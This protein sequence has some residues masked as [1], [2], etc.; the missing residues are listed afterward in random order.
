MLDVAETSNWNLNKYAINARLS[1]LSTNSMNTL[2]NDLLPMVSPLQQ[3]PADWIPT[4]GTIISKMGHVTLKATGGQSKM[5]VFSALNIGSK[6]IAIV[7]LYNVNW[8]SAEAAGL[9]FQSYSQRLALMCFNKSIQKDYFLFESFTATVTG[10]IQLV[11]T[12]NNLA[13]TGIVPIGTSLVE[14]DSNLICIVPWTQAL[15]DMLSL[16]KSNYTYGRVLPISAMK[17]LDNKPV[18]IPVVQSLLLKSSYKK[19]V[20]MMIMYGQSLAVGGGAT[21]DMTNKK[22][23]L[24]FAGGYNEYASNL[25]IS[26][27]AQVSAYY[28]TDLVLLQSLSGLS[29]SPAGAAAVAWMQL[30]EAENVIDLTSFDY[31]FLLSTPGYS[32][33]SITGLIKGQVYYNRLLL[34]VQKGFELSLKAGKTFGVPV[35]FYVQ[36]EADM[37][38]STASFYA[39]LKQLFIDLNT[40][41]KAITGQT[42]DVKFIPYQ[43]SPVTTQSGYENSGPSFAQLQLALEGGNVYSAASMYQYTYGVGDMWHPA[44]RAVVG[45]QLGIIAK[46]I[47][48][49]ENPY[50]V[51][52]PKSRFV[53]NSGS[54]WVLNIEFNVP[55]APMRFDVSGDLWHNPNGKQVNYGFKLL[56]SSLANIISAEPTIKRGNTLVI[57]CTENPTGAKLSYAIDGHYG[58]GNLCDSQKIT[59]VN[60]STNYVVDN[61]CVAF[62]D[63][64]I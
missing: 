40:D 25:D 2:Q 41:I 51:F 14:F 57:K 62:K 63:Y 49:D 7:N 36:G 54:Y 1:D 16:V 52:Y 53:Q 61:F 31:Q 39:V 55:V 20:N 44:D 10:A 23:T 38:W 19:D 8:L 34:S 13:N 21:D 12:G 37:T 9:D 18:A 33:I 50:P 48:N 28:G 11:A 4:T 15:E 6:Y 47:V 29:H 59:I 17:A 5:N 24:S 58:G 64:V 56:N 26:V 60:K 43:T 45:Q 27:P 46:R 30:L 35:L 42:E 22:K 32:G 3:N